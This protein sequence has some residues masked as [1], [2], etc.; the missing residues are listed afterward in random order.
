LTKSNSFVNSV[1]EAFKKINDE[2]TIDTLEHDFSPRLGKYFCESVLGYNSEEI[3][4]ER[5][6][7]DVTLFDEN[8]F[9]TVLIE[10]K[11][12]KE[13]LGTEKWQ[14]Q[15][16]KYADST[17]RYIGLTNGFRFLLWEI[18]KGKRIPQV[19]I[20]FD[21]LFKEEKFT[22]EKI[23]TQIANQILFLEHIT[24]KEIWNASKY[25]RFDDFYATIDVSE[26]DGFEKLL[27]RIKYIINNLL[28]KYTD[29]TFDEYLAGYHEYQRKLSELEDLKKISKEKKLN[30]MEPEIVDA[31][32]RIDAKYKKYLP[33]VG[34][35]EWLSLSN[36]SN[37]SDEENKQVFCKESIYV[38]LNRLLF[39]RICE[40][41][42]LLKKRISN[43]G[44]EQLRELLSENPDDGTDDAYNQIVISTY[45]SASSIY[46]HLFEKGNPLVWYE[47]A[48]EELNRALKIILWTLNQFNFSK[49][50][51]D[52]L[53][54]IYEQYLP[55]D[56]RK[57]LGEFYTPDEIIDYIL[58]SVDYEPSKVIE[59][60]DLIDPACGS[61]GFLVRACRRLIGRYAVKFGKASPKESIDMKKW[62]DVLNRLSPKECSTIIDGIRNHIHGFD[63]N[64]FAVHIS[65][66]NMLFQIIDLYQKVRKSN[67]KFEFGRFKIFQTD[68]LELPGQ[69][70]LLEFTSPTGQLLA[71]DISEIN[72]LKNKKYDYVVGNPPWLGILTIPKATLLQYKKYNTAKGKFDIYVLFIE[73]GIKLLSEKGKL[74]YITQNRFIK[75]GYAKALREFIRDNSH[76]L[77][78]A[79]F[80]DLKLFEDAVNYPAIIILQTKSD[81]KLFSY[82]EFKEKA[83]ELDSEELLKE[84]KKNLVQ[85]EIDTDI[86]RSYNVEQ[87][88]LK[89]SG[90]TFGSPESILLFNKLDSL[91]KLEEFSEE[92]KQ[93]VT[94]GGVGTA[95]IYFLHKEKS[96]EL[97]IEKEFLKEYY[98][99]SDI[100]KYYVESRED[101]LLYPYLEKGKSIDL[102]FYPRIKKYFEPYKNLLSNRKLDGKLITEWG[103]QWFELWRERDPEIFNKKKIICP[104]VAEINRFAIDEDFNFLSDSAVAII[105]NKINLHLMLGILN[106]KLAQWLIQEHISPFV[107]GRYYNYSKLYVERI[108]IQKPS[109]MKE[110]D[111]AKK[112]I[113][114]VKKI[115]KSIKNNN[116]AEAKKIADSVD[117][118]VFEL[119]DL[120]E[121]EKKLVE[122]TV[123]DKVKF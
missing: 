53:G 40:D 17:T 119:Y 47:S 45:S 30:K 18:K 62:N 23:P 107:Q 48:S 109:N 92:I 71:K 1:L 121:Q 98:R 70:D 88:S 90:W 14:T 87:S 118:S 31:K 61:G 85:D 94:T 72:S 4:Y 75:V 66:M 3:R 74:G 80:G 46:S 41:K 106:S 16:G 102:K 84:L 7:T 55:K 59:E 52:I 111:L 73:L 81:G 43:G 54:R 89:N 10:T 36:R 99:G 114:D 19:D 110:E 78:L 69:T 25:D 63:I 51:R 82:T 8:N 113:E 60:K 76:I 93:G 64:P 68:S 97:K 105:P 104:R 101:I 120:T 34:Y 67:P 123:N 9:R 15:A 2:I 24:K 21:E 79:N 103:K 56:E 33:F 11:R 27:E 35:Y 6:R 58:D 100:R 29:D 96:D 38:F 116:M 122:N 83:K 28:K 5:G 13:N 108:P 49:I 50:D 57:R 39:I 112:I 91:P 77:Q 26:K 32:L 86:L 22:D 117:N 115:Q 37:K 12:P 44:I 20:S 42:G 95:S 65:E